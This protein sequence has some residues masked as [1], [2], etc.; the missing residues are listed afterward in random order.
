MS[1][2]FAML[3][4]LRNL[5]NPDCT[6]LVL[7]DLCY[8]VKRVDRQDVCRTFNEMERHKDDTALDPW[9]DPG[10]YL[11]FA[12]AGHCPDHFLVPY[13]K[14]LCLVR[15]DLDPAGRFLAFEIR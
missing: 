14:F 12:P 9:G 13:A 1:P 11:D 2:F 6:G 8:R 5:L 4:R 7:R 15:I 3:L 10:R